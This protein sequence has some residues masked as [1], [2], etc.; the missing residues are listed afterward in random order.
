MK[1]KIPQDK[2]DKII[3]KYL[4]LNLKGLEKRKANY[5]EG[6]VFAY[7]DEEFGVLA[8]KNNGT[9]FIY[10]KLINE[11]SNG[12]GLEKSD[13]KSIITRWASNRFKLEVNNTVVCTQAPFFLLAIDYN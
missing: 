7:P 1:Y 13:S 2:I 10:Y 9:F 3:F 12:F 11:I 8:Y 5:Y 4:D 6:I